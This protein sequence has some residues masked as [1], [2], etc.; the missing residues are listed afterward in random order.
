MRVISGQYPD[1]G[2]KGVLG[3]VENR[4]KQQQGALRQRNPDGECLLL[5]MENCG[6]LLKYSCQSY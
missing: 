6:G 3:E 5:S 1:L 4:F 2:G